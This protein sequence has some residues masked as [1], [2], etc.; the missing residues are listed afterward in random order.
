MLQEGETRQEPIS[1]E[2]MHPVLCTVTAQMA[3]IRI[4]VSKSLLGCLKKQNSFYENSND[5]LHLSMV[6]S[7]S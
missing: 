2:N 7:N 1:A 3:V 5:F 6:Q 4:S